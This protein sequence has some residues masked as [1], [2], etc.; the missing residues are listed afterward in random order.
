MSVLRFALR[1][2]TSSAENLG[3]RFHTVEKILIV[4]DETTYSYALCELLRADGFETEWASGAKQAL[5]C[6]QHSIPDLLLVDILLPDM[7]GLALIRLIREQPDLAQ[8]PIIVISGRTMEDDRTQSMLAGA[9]AFL[10][11]PFSRDQL[12]EAIHPFFPAMSPSPSV[13]SAFS[14]TS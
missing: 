6:L 1:R 2:R 7:N 8:I 11:K 10:S 13:S 9:D 4:D 3:W 14:N 5:E 12:R